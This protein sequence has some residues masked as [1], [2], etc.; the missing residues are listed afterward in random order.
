MNGKD[1][2]FMMNEYG[3]TAFDADWGVGGISSVDKTKFVR[4]DKHGLYGIGPRD[5]VVHDGTTWKPIDLNDIIDNATFALTWQGL[6]VTGN[7][8]V[9]ARIGKLNGD[10]INIKNNTGSIF[11]VGNNGSS[12]IAGWSFDSRYLT[13]DND[14]FIVRLSSPTTLD[15]GTVDSPST[16]DSNRVLVVGVKNNGSTSYPFYLTSGGFLH[17]DKLH[18]T[19]GKIAGWT[20][21]ADQLSHC[22]TDKSLGQAGTFG[23]YPQGLEIDLSNDFNGTSK[24]ESGDAWVLTAGKD[25]GLTKNGML[26]ANSGYLG[27]MEIGSAASKIGRNLYT[28]SSSLSGSEWF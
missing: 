11:Q 13:A 18:A 16:E 2:T 26:F 14:N 23:V 24:L 15:T 3:I 25:F 20:I 9:E 7:D 1:I 6:K 5:G 21:S 19:G 22:D 27:G 4:F 8:G 10:I 28:N 12:K 17:T